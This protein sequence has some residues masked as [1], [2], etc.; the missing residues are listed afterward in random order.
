[1]SNLHK[2]F[3]SMIGLCTDAEPMHSPLHGHGHAPD[4]DSDLYEPPPP[5]PEGFRGVFATSHT[6]AMGAGGG[7]PT[8]WRDDD[9]D[10][11]GDELPPPPPPEGFQGV[12]TAAE[13]LSKAQPRLGDHTVMLPR[14][15]HDCESVVSAAATFGAVRQLPIT[16]RPCGWPT[17]MQVG[18]SEADEALETAAITAPNPEL[19]MAPRTTAPPLVVPPTAEELTTALEASEEASG[20]PPMAREGAFSGWVYKRGG[21]KSKAWKRRYCV[22]VAVADCG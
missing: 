10:D 14:F 1:M 21:L 3:S 6:S 12:F 19:K 18:N 4:S 22:C 11:D 16:A 17:S 5:P 8:S 20:V 2:P 15:T 7:G 13:C 9:D